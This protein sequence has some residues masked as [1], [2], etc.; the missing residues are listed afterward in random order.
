MNSRVIKDIPELVETIRE[1]RARTKDYVIPAGG[2]DPVVN[3]D[4]EDMPV[5]VSLRLK[6][7]GGYTKWGVE[8]QVHG[9][10]AGKTGINAHYYRK[11]MAEA[12]DL[13]QTNLKYWFEKLAEKGKRYLV[14]MLDLNVRAFLSD[15]YR[16]IDHLD[17]LTTAVKIITGQGAGGVDYAQGA[18]CFS[19]T[20]TPTNMNVCLFNPAMQVDLN[21]LDKGVQFNGDWERD[22]HGWYKAKDTREVSDRPSPDKPHVVFPA[23]RITNSET[24]HG[25]LGIQAGFAELICSNAAWIGEKFGTRHLGKTLE[26][27]DVLSPDT[28]RKQN[29][30]IYAKTGDY[31]RQVFSPEK[32]L[33]FCKKTKGLQE[34]EVDPKEAINNIAK[35][36]N[37]TEDM[38]E[39]ILAAYSPIGNKDTMLDVQRAVT[40]AAQQYQE[41]SP[42]K[43]FVLEELGGT[44]IEKPELATK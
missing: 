1:Q 21:D 42:D 31:V 29:E 24:G 36:D 44:L 28:I 7:N 13:L 33:E 41:E 6:T 32:L 2:I 23:C 19:W 12:P 38:R 25:G 39:D 30:V 11:M 3:Y 22:S 43:T 10:L 18:K 8:S 9:Q 20:L 5:E 15:R 40:R 16:P 4:D 27:D 17:L 14:R 34:I 37:I 35:L 26:V